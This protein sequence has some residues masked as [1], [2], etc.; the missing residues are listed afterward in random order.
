MIA[1][2]LEAEHHFR[3]LQGYRANPK[4]VAALRAMT[5][6]DEATAENQTSFPDFANRIGSTSSRFAIF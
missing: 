2:V 6:V 1:S 5:V 3:K 4:L